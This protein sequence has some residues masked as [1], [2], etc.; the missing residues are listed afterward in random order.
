MTTESTAQTGGAGTAAGA[1]GKGSV[2][3]S[4]NQGGAGSVGGHGGGGAGAG[5]TDD[6][7]GGSQMDGLPCKTE[8]VTCSFGGTSA[9]IEYTCTNGH[10]VEQVIQIAVAVGVSSSS[11][12]N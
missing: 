9:Y 2:G 3:G 8:G 10:W 1:G 5:P 7:T 11:T 4:G 6:C 12:G